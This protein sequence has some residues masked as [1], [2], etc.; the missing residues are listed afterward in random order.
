[1]V[2]RYKLTGHRLRLEMLPLP[3]CCWLIPSIS[4]FFLTPTDIT[5]GAVGAAKPYAITKQRLP[6]I[7]TIL[8]V[9]KTHNRIPIT[10]SQGNCIS[11]LPVIPAK[12]VINGIDKPHFKNT[13]NSHPV[14]ITLITLPKPEAKLSL[15]LHFILTRIQLMTSDIALLQMQRMKHQRY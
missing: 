7:A 13:L 10:R 8:F 11:I 12:D 1:M 9:E 15:I 4:Y 3:V 5:V 2:L 6:Q 14:W